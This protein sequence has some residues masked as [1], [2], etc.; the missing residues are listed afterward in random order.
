MGERRTCEALLR[1]LRTA[2]VPL[3][4][5]EG[6][7][8]LRACEG[9]TMLAPDST[10][11]QRESTQPG[12]SPKQGRQQLGTRIACVGCEKELLYLGGWSS[13]LFVVDNGCAPLPSPI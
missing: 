1:A 7:N 8:V 13:T 11:G 10:Y 5:E 12:R 2:R 3:Y 4:C 9:P 6:A